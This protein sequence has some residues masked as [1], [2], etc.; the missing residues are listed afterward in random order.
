VIIDPTLYWEVTEDDDQL[1]DEIYAI[2][3]YA[4][5]IGKPM[6]IH[7]SVKAL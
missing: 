2:M 1:H 6:I 5:S 7:F 3:D 4:S